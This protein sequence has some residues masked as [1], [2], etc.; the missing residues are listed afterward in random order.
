M[1]YSYASIP[2]TR[3]T[4]ITPKYTHIIHNKSVTKSKDDYP[5]PSTE[6]S[7]DLQDIISRVLCKKKYSKLKY[8]FKSKTSIKV[9]AE[10]VQN[11]LALYHWKRQILSI[12]NSM[13]PTTCTMN[14]W[15]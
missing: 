15:Q 8:S 9:I 11:S 1:Y 14:S 3:S 12:I 2:V 7:S 6:P 10:N 13:N 4:F 5:M